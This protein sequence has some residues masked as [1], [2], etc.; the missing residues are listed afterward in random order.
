MS[1]SSK[2]VLPSLPRI[3]TKRVPQDQDEVP[4]VVRALEPR[5]SQLAAVRGHV[6][7]LHE[8]NRLLRPA[9]RAEAK[10]G[11]AGEYIAVELDLG[12][13]SEAERDMTYEMQK[14]SFKKAIK[15]NAPPKM[16]RE[17]SVIHEELGPFEIP[18]Y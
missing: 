17:P 3:A 15:I 18:T 2:S 8:K 12:E 11:I 7:D 6:S 1:R 16:S 14:N 10:E 13:I 9:W 5:P 4:W